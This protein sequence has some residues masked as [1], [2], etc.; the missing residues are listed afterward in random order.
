MK[1]RKKRNPNGAGRKLFDGQPIAIVLQKLD[2]AFRNGCTDEEAALYADISAA[3]LYAYQKKTPG[4]L[5]RKKLLKQHPVLTARG[6]VVKALSH[7]SELALK[8]L[9][10]KKKDEFSPRTEHT[11]PDGEG[12]A[13][14]LDTPKKA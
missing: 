13:I 12:F 11:G 3:A 4:F 2:D 9:E 8:F 5:E 1:K 14:V 10:R 6:T 7:D